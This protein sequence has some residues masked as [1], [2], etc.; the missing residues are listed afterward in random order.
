M[1]VVLSLADTAV[2]LKGLG[3]IVKLLQERNFT[4]S[5]DQL[6]RCLSGD[7]NIYLCR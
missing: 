3:R 6:F 7:L 5:K 1:V 2:T 4:Q